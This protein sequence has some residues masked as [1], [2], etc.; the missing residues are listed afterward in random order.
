MASSDEGW[1]STRARNETGGGM[2]GVK[3]ADVLLEGREGE[4][5][6]DP[7]NRPRQRIGRQH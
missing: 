4:S 5:P 1:R 2:T 6:I 7:D 3:V